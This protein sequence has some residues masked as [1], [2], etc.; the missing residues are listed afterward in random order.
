VS[1]AETFDFV[2]LLHVI[3]SLFSTV[4]MSVLCTAYGMTE[5]TCA[6]MRPPPE[7]KNDKNKPGTVGILLANMEVK[8]SDASNERQFFFVILL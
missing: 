2:I 4:C 1:D 6:A 5:V 3:S 7:L 8:V